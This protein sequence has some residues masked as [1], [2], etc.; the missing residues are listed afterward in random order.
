MG[1]FG[2][3]GMREDS[4]GGGYDVSVGAGWQGYLKTVSA[5][6]VS[7]DGSDF[8]MLLKLFVAL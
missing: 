2:L 7:T 4:I 5:A 3:V 6:L 1:W 8:F